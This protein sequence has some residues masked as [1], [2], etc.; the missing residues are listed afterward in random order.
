MKYI[1]R[2]LVL[3]LISY[4]LIGNTNAN[5]ATYNGYLYLPGQSIRSGQFAQ[6]EL[7]YLPGSNSGAVIKM[8]NYGNGAGYSRIKG[9][10]SNGWA[11][12]WVSRNSNGF[13]NINIPK[14]PSYHA[15]IGEGDI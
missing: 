12:P 4:I 1:K 2:L 9:F 7:S 3:S 5:A 15:Q 10:N 11:S 14:A 8:T 6:F 13:N